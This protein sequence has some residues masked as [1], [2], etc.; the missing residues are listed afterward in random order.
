MPTERPTRFNVVLDE[1]HAEKLLV[2]AE[3][4][5]MQPGALARSLLSGAIDAADPDPQLMTDI[6]NS[7]PGFWEGVAEAEAEAEAGL[8]MTIEEFVASFG[9]RV[10]P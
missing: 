2:M 6:L 1:E 3:R 7:I 4:A 5:Y 9:E 8:G 10:Q